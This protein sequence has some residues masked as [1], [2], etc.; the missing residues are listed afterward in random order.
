MQSAVA[1]VNDNVGQLEDQLLGSGTKDALDAYR[2][3]SKAMFIL[4]AVAFFTTLATL[5]MSLFAICSR[6]GSL[7][8]WILSAVSPEKQFIIWLSSY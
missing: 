8:T 6:W 4:Y 3:A 5:V 1:Y 7:C 2:R